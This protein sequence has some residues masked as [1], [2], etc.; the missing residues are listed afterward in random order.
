MCTLYTVSQIIYLHVVWHLFVMPILR[1]VMYAYAHCY[2]MSWKCLW[3]EHMNLMWEYWG[4]DWTT[5]STPKIT[6]T[7]WFSQTSH[8]TAHFQ[9]YGC[10][11]Y[12]H[13]DNEKPEFEYLQKKT[14]MPRIITSL[15]VNVYGKGSM[16]CN[17]DC[18]YKVKYTVL[19][20]FFIAAVHVLLFLSN[21]KQH[22]G[23]N[24]IKKHSFTVSWC[25][26]NFEVVMMKG[27]HEN[28]ELQF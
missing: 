19:S 20:D 21:Q 9:F 6:I 28:L 22:G 25:S 13:E 8:L 10:H 15:Y 1:T 27:Y 3:T 2:V 18:T 4:D 17:N 7:C 16:T 5:L 24:N 23:W 26:A 11:S 12:A 14:N